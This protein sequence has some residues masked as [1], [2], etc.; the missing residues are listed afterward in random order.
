MRS[1]NNIHQLNRWAAVDKGQQKKYFEQRTVNIK[2]QQRYSL[3]KG[4]QGLHGAKVCQTCQK[5]VSRNVR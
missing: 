4:L 3:S 5:S 2:K 1:V